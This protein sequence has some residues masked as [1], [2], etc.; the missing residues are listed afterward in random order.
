MALLL[1][2]SGGRIL[3]IS[4]SRSRLPEYEGARQILGDTY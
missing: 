2:S 4:I 3:L 1:L